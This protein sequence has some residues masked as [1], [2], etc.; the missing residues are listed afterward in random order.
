[1][2]AFCAQHWI[3]ANR[4][5]YARD[6]SPALDLALENYREHNRTCP[7]CQARYA[8]IANLSKPNPDLI[9]GQND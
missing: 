9:E 4:V 7:E 8:E 3:L 2:A 5:I 6:Y 1:M